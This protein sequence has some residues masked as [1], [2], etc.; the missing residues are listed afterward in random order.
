MKNFSSASLIILIIFISIGSSG[1]DRFTEIDA[2]LQALSLKDAPGLNNLVELSVDAISMQDFLRGLA[3]ANEL[4]VTVDPSINVKVINNFNGVSVKDVF[5]FVCRQY[6]LKIDLIGPIMSF[7]P[8]VEPVQVEKYISKK[9][10]ISYDKNTDLVS[11]DFN[12]DSLTL[13]AREITR[14][15]SKN[16]VFTP[17]L[18]SRLVNGFIQSMPFNN[19]MEKLAFANDF[20]VTLSDDGFYLLEKVNKEQ[21]SKTADK[22]G[23]KK[24][25]SRDLKISV[26]GLLVSVQATNLPLLDVISEVSRQM[27]KDFYLFS[28]IKGNTTVNVKDVSMDDLLSQL[29]SGTNLTFKKHGNAYIFGERNIEGL[30]ITK[31]IQLQYRT[32]NK[33]LEVIP[34]DLKKDVDIKPFPDLN[35]MI[36]SGSEPNILEIERFILEIDRVVPV[37]Q[38]EVLI[39]DIQRNHSVA[40]GIE[41][42]LSDE[43][44]STSGTLFPGVDLTLGSDA[45]NDLISGINGFGS[46]NL[47]NVTPNFY[48][49]LRAMEQQGLLKIRSTPQLATLNGNKANLSIGRTE[50]YLEISNNVITNQSTQFVQTQNYKPITAELSLEINP[51][52]SGDE[53]ITLDISVKQSSFTQRVGEEGPFGTI[54]RDFASLIRVKN[55]EMIMLGGL[56]ES[57]IND[58]GTGV[59]FLSRVP[60]L[61]WFFSSRIRSKNKSRLTIFIK[62]TIIY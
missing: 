34:G 48:L 58:S 35:G 31:L 33:V 51:I 19:A 44:V 52:V 53:Q 40:T 20:K 10:N 9:V 29:F 24:E 50:Y 13:V 26:N 4:N 60:V 7:L 39:V 45:I 41:A 54:S 6:S 49:K 16:I 28:E 3:I 21:D 32:I 37:V 42:G 25:A 57:T 47:G 55:G 61:K 11:W 17:E 46:V 23:S 59:P 30:R 5:V 8:Y 2:K 62:P 43:P 38:I 15:T 1:Q 12:G 56:E 14:V 18:S 36:V 22:T 27:G